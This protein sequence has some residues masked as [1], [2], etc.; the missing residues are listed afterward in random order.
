M[1]N[2][3][4]P[5]AFSSGLLKS[6]KAP[7]IIPPY[8]RAPDGVVKVAKGF[9]RG[10]GQSGLR[11]VLEV[12]G[13]GG[14]GPPEWVPSD[15]KI[16]IDLVG[17]RA[18]TETD[19]VVTVDTLLGADPNTSAGWDTTEYD[20]ARLT[21]DGY[22]EHD[23]PPALIGGARTKVVAGATVI[24]KMKQITSTQQTHF[25]FVKIAADGSDALEFDLQAP[26]QG[27][28]GHAFEWSGPLDHNTTAT[29]SGGDGAINIAAITVTDARFDAAVNGSPAIAGAHSAVDLIAV[30]I[31]AG[32]G[33]N[34]ALQSV[35]IYDPLPST[36]GLSELTV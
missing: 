27:S 14:G 28:V 5:N 11:P 29:V 25:P 31:D 2:Y 21:A 19:G 13:G 36:A 16:F 33:V 26:A 24:I 15:A 4:G 7:K 10:G 22:V 9:A 6:A 23:H 1:T 3:K 17:N 32:A 18:W 8:Q 30:V 12:A 34:T 35:A 20:P